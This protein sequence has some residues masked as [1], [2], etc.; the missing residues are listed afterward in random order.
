MTHQYREFSGI[1]ERAQQMLQGEEGLEVEFKQSQDSLDIGDIIA[2]ANSPHGGT[3]LIGIKETQKKDGR[4]KGI[5][6][7]CRVGDKE[8]L[9]LVS[10]I[11]NITPQLTVEIFVE[12]SARRPFYR[13]EI[14]S[15]PLKPY[16][17]SSGEYKI[18]DDG[19]VKPLFPETMLEILLDRESEKFRRRF[20]HSTTALEEAIFRL[21]KGSKKELDDVEKNL[22][23]LNSRIGALL[24]KLG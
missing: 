24:K 14:P 18:R 22:A 7:G 6:V 5:I 10:K 16:C 17:S 8:K 23:T 19:H 4:Q 11:N 12:N 2:F 1:S 20:E 9:K 15:G 21:A 13:V 3:V